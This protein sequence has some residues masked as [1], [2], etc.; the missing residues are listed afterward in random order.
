M[1]A[2]VHLKNPKELR[3]LARET[4]V[5]TESLREAAE[6][7]R[8]HRVDRGL[9]L[10]QGRKKSKS[11]YQEKLHMPAVAHERWLSL[12]DFLSMDPAAA[13]RG[14]I[15]EY[16]LY[17]PE[18]RTRE[19][20]W[21]VDGR[22]YRVPRAELR[23][24]QPAISRGAALALAHRGRDLG[25]TRPQ[26][27]RLLMCEAMANLRKIRRPIAPR[28]MYEDPTRYRVTS[29]RKKPRGKGAR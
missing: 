26:L 19:T 20:R 5:T 16:L 1:H 17:G 3:R 22:A 23:W 8:Q 2:F 4:G 24:L 12:C 15:H 18:V 21:I 9:P 6:R 13:V 27:I 10:P 14:L 29:D 28:A 11:Y 25:L 7:V